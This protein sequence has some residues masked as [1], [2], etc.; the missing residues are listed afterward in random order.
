MNGLQAK[1]YNIIKV[2]DLTYLWEIDTSVRTTANPT[3]AEM[4][5]LSKKMRSLGLWS[6]SDGNKYELF[7]SPTALR[8]S[9]PKVPYTMRCSFLA[10]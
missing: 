2:D 10:R 9:S 5:T 6:Y 7:V 8:M 3:I 1:G 4:H